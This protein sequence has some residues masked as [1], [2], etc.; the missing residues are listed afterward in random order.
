[1]SG[2]EQKSYKVYLGGKWIETGEKIHV[3]NP[4]TGEKFASVSTL[5]RRSGARGIG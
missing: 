5:D 1:M 3:T 2:N 4:A